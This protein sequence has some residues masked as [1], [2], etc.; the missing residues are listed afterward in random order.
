MTEIVAVS[1]PGINVLTA[2]DPDDLQFSSDYNT[3]KYYS[4]GTALGTIS[5]TNGERTIS[6]NLGYVPFFTA[7]TNVLSPTNTYSM[8]PQTFS[9]F[10]AYL[11]IN[12]YADTANIY[13]RWE[14]A[15]AAATATFYYKI[16]RNNLRF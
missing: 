3:L 1:K 12:G 11:Y 7:F 10:G 5:S 15:S 14:T 13:L 2:S 4:S 8:L 16:F 6:H 9:D